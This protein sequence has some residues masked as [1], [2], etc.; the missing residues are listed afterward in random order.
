MNGSSFSTATDSTNN[1]NSNSNMLFVPGK[2]AF[3]GMENAP[4][5]RFIFEVTPNSPEQKLSIIEIQLY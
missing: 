1:S 2:I 4:N 5:V 3:N